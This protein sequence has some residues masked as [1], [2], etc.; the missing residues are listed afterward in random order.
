[1]KRKKYLWDTTYIKYIFIK[2][3]N[4]E[5]FFDMENLQQVDFTNKKDFDTYELPVIKS[6]I[7]YENIK[8]SDIEE[9]T[10]GVYSITHDKYTNNGRSFKRVITITNKICYLTITLELGKENEDRNNI[11]IEMTSN[12]EITEHNYKGALIIKSDNIII[13]DIFH[14]GN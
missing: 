1:M 7:N 2:H 4:D 6:D 10:K 12:K 9:S 3:H 11:A 5:I 14:I 13:P 8:I